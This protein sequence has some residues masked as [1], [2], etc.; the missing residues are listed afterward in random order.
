MKAK[1]SIIIFQLGLIVFAGIVALALAWRSQDSLAV[2][3]R[4]CYAA[5]G[6]SFLIGSV[7]YY[8]KPC[9]GSTILIVSLLSLIVTAPLVGFP[10]W[11]NGS[12][13]DRVGLILGEIIAAG[14]VSE[15]LL[16]SYDKG[17]A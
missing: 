1:K 7:A 4:V 13:A 3:V 15:P 6:I 11:T 5:Y 17:N 12:T 2:S 8:A 16:R 14:I 10:V 9:I